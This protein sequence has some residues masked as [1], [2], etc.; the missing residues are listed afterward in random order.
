M[1]FGIF[2]ASS[3]SH[4]LSAHLQRSGPD[5]L[6]DAWAAS[7]LHKFKTVLDPLSRGCFAAVS[8][9][10]AETIGE[11]HPFLKAMKAAKAGKGGPPPSLETDVQSL[12]GWVPPEGGMEAEDERIELIWSK[13]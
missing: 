11:R 6:I 7:R 9:S 3:L 5:S 12:E 1:S 8:S 10:D 13:A 2:D 4:V